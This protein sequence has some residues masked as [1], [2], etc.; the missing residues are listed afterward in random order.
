MD[1]KTTITG[2]EIRITPNH[3][4]RTFTLRTSYAKYRTDPFP[5]QEFE[6]ARRNWTG[7]DWM[8][9]LKTN[10]YSVIK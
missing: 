4:K 5:K 6:S 2:E 10:S 1:I 9:F 3:S 7:N 8:Q